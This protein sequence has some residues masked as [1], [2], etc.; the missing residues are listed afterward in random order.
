MLP[1]DS[2]HHKALFALRSVTA[3]LVE[4]THMRTDASMQVGVSVA[5][6]QTDRTQTALSFRVFLDS[7]AIKLCRSFC[8]VFSNGWIIMNI[9]EN[10]RDQ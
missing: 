5:V 9:S 1:G 8:R 6:C 3:A 10:D 4:Q 2:E 7:A